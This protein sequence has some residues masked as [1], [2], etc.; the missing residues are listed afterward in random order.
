MAGYKKPRKYSN[1]EDRAIARKIWMKQI[2]KQNKERADRYD[3]FQR[4]IDMHKLMVMS[5]GGQTNQFVIEPMGS[6][7]V[8]FLLNKAENVI[9]IDILKN[10]DDQT[11]VL[12]TLFAD[13]NFPSAIYDV[14]AKLNQ[15]LVVP[16]I[17]IVE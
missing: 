15:Q 1:L 8:H 14:Y 11:G 9:D 3:K 6:S 12:V 13:A 2:T 7:F 17:T 5:N 10:G 4:V 16:T